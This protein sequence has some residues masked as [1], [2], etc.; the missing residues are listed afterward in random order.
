MME[1]S[2]SVALVAFIPILYVTACAALYLGQERLIFRRSRQHPDRMR[3]G[4]EDMEEVSLEAEDGVR[5]YAWYKP[6]RTAARLL[7]YLP[8]DY[9]HVGHRGRRLRFFLDRDLGA[10]VLAYRGFSGNGGRPSE[11]GLARDANA[12]L[13]F[14]ARNNIAAR[15]IV[16]YGESLGGAVAVGLAAGCAPAGLVL[17]AAFANFAD[18][19]AEKLWLFPVRLM[20]HHRFP[21]ADLIASVRAPILILHGTSDRTVPFRHAERLFARACNPKSLWPAVGAGHFD[22]YEFG[23][24]EIVCDFIARLPVCL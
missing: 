5:T 2:L 8:G 11:E 9:G 3:A 17:E 15:R 1:V 18:L 23:A 22:L 10:L 24:G 14:L 4:L 20:L 7:L 13:A 12:A 19:A 21:S 16:I 6:P